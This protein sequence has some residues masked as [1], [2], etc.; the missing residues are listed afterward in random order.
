MVI[1]AN[2]IENLEKKAMDEKCD[3]IGI[4]EMSITYTQPAD[5]CSHPDAT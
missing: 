3:V 4:E 1:P 5:T 2:F